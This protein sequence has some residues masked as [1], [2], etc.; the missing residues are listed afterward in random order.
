MLA[1]GPQ[2]IYGKGIWDVNSH[3][4]LDGVCHGFK[5]TD[6]G[7]ALD[8]YFCKNYDSATITA[9]DEIEAIIK[10]ELA[11]GKLTVVEDQP[12]CVHALGAVP[13]SSGGVR[14]IT[15][16][17]RPESLSINNF[18]HQTF[19][20]FSYKSVDTVSDA[21]VSG[22]YMAVTDI[23]A[24]YRSVLVRPSDRTHQGLVWNLGGEDRY[25]QDNFLSFGTRVAPYIFNSITD[26]VSRFM[27]AHGLFCVN[28]LDDFL[29]MGSDYESCQ[30]AQYFLHSVLRS[31]GFYISYKKVRSPSRV[32]LYL[33]V[34][35]D[36]IEMQLRLPQEKLEKLYAELSFFSG[37][38]RATKRQLQQLCGVL[39]HCSTLVRG[40]RTFS[41]RIIAMLSCFTS[42]KRYVTL[43]ASFQLDLD[44]WR[45]FAAWFNGTARI[46]QPPRH[47]TMVCTDA[48]G[49]GFGAFT[50]VDWICGRWE[51]DM[52]FD[53]DHHGHCVPKPTVDVPRNI[54]VR[55]LY[56]ILEAVWRWGHLWRDH[57]VQCVS[58][59]TQVVAAINTGRSVNLSSM[60]ILREIFWQSVIY[61]FHLVGVYLPGKEN[62]VA[63]ALS[64]VSSPSELPVFLCCRSGDATQEAGP[65]GSRT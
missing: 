13:K 59:N 65:T 34:E 55:E 14:P 32:Q 53:L 15:D 57:K 18:M 63:D 54:N 2:E 21:M 5:L 44:W 11:S 23:S 64:R 19:K 49:S 29:V 12:L 51:E 9:H 36:S 46:V 4:L 24:A 27:T 20:S 30:Q 62:V 26:A 41:H 60:I 3:F 37:R 31:L 35:L 56:P 7:I 45:D 16:A 47:T 50:G 22:C 61:N 52:Q 48:S 33:G 6:P 40:G 38:R 8:G 28:Y 17:S 39:A 58:D 25:V 1:G 42:K 43:S 10:D